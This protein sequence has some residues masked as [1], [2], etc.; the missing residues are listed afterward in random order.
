MVS[1]GVK[2]HLF[3]LV[4]N[5]CSQSDSFRCISLYMIMSSAHPPLSSMEKQRRFANNHINNNNNSLHLYST[6]LLFLSTQSAL[7]CEGY[8]LV[9]LQ[10]AASTW[11]ILCQNATTHQLTGGEKTEWWSQSVDMGMVRRPWCSAAK[12]QIWPG[13]QGHTS[14]LFERHP[15]FFMITERSPKDGAFW[16]YSVPRAGP[17]HRRNRQMLG[18]PQIPGAPKVFF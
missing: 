6:F 8:L 17:W 10:C 5:S 1:V 15:G 7:H 18:A 13:C 14:T 2:Q 12:G 16:Q 4:T 11:M 3:Y 9:H